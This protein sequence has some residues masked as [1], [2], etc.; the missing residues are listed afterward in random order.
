M[1]TSKP[2]C[3]ASKSSPAPPCSTRAAASSLCEVGLP[4][5][6]DLRQSFIRGD[7]VYTAAED[8]AGTITV[9]RYRLMLPGKR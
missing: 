7:E 6:V 2:W 9:K 8:E 1:K 4:A 5:G 3:R